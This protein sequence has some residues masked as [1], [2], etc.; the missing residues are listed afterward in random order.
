L[1]VSAALNW[2]ICAFQ[3]CCR[4]VPLCA[5][6][7]RERR[8]SSSHAPTLPPS[9]RRASFLVFNDNIGSLIMAV[10]ALASIGSCAVVLFLLP[11]RG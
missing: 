9:Q 2:E 6:Q 10:L 7:C 8:P 11:S 5:G 4:L 1:V 3:R